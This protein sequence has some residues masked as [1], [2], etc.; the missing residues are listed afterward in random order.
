MVY[1]EEATYYKVLNSMLICNVEM[2][3]KKTSAIKDAIVMSS[4][5]VDV[6]L[7]LSH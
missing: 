4:F 7:G 5:S 6:K 2:L 3:L 1:L